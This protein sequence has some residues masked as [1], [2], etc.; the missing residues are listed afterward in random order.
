MVFFINTQLLLPKGKEKERDLN[1][2][3]PVTG[4]LE[5]QR[6]LYYKVI[7]HFFFHTPFLKDNFKDGWTRGNNFLF[8]N[9]QTD[10]NQISV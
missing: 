9:C 8:M 6:N 1:S 2:Q 5:K 4:H 10:K 3:K 7:P